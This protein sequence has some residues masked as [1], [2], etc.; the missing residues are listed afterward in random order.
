MPLLRGCGRAVSARVW[1]AVRSTKASESK[2]MIRSYEV[3]KSVGRG[4]GVFAV[5]HFQP[6]ETVMIGVFDQRSTRNHA[7]ASQVGEA[8]YATHAGVISLVNHSC[9]PNCGISVNTSGAHDFVAMR[10]I[11][12]DEELTFDYA[13]RNYRIEHFPK[14]CGCGTQSCR[15]SITG[16]A[17]LLPEIKDRYAGFVAPYLIE[18]DKN[19]RASATA[20]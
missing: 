19:E 12:P 17:D 4:S 2:S 16:W 10:A 7:H 5:R 11:K 14:S 15:G 6:L 3:R 1:V 20:A 8:K 18:L 13:M 9:E